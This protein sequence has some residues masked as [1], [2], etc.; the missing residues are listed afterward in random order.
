M[1]DNNAVEPQRQP[2]VA[3]MEIDNADLPAII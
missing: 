2:S 1:Y 3:E